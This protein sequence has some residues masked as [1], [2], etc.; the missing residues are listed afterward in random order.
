[1]D[2]FGTAHGPFLL[3]GETVVSRQPKRT[4]LPSF[5]ILLNAYRP[6]SLNRDYMDCTPYSAAAGLC[7]N[8]RSL[9]IITVV[10]TLLCRQAVAKPQFRRQAGTDRRPFQ[11][12]PKV[13]IRKLSPSQGI[14]RQVHALPFYEFTRQI[15]FNAR[16][17]AL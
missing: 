17:R 12:R 1:M 15:L 10:G 2:D 13:P 14:K 5:F 7:C 6:R 16:C 9:T 3:V 4:V 8:T 11:S